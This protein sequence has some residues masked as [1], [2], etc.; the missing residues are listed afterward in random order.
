[1]KI[2]CDINAKW[3]CHMWE[4][5]ANTTLIPLTVWK[6]A[7]E[8]ICTFTSLWSGNKRSFFSGGKKH[9][10]KIFMNA[11]V[12][13]KFPVE[14][15]YGYRG[16]IRIMPFQCLTPSGNRSTWSV[17]IKLLRWNLQLAVYCWCFEKIDIWLWIVS[18]YLKEKYRWILF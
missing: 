14:S 2:K 4:N 5:L 13:A 7:K 1:M 12:F 15:S 17:S 6:P 3:L 16:G 8:R 18:H 9:V 10:I 11:I